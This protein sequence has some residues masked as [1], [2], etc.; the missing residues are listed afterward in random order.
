MS[1]PPELV[2]DANVWID[3]VNGQLASVIFNL[4]CEILSTDLVIHEVRGLDEERLVELG[5]RIESLSGE[6]IQRLINLS[7]SIAGVSVRDLSAYMLAQERE[8]LLITGDRRLR[9]YA[10]QEG[11]RVHGILWL[12]DQVVEV[13][14]INP[15]RAARSLEAIR[16]HGARLPQTECEKRLKKWQGFGL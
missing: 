14:A 7:K 11:V 1:S 5:L 13:E 3:L 8:A 12:L 2:L 10:A 4:D 15:E 6:D 16:V 9:N